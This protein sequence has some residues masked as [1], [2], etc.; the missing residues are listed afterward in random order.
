VNDRV[1]GDAVSFEVCA[2]ARTPYCRSWIEKPEWEEEP[3][4]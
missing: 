4:G 1:P 3:E 2:E